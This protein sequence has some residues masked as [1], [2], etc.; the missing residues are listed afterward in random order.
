ATV[1]CPAD[2]IAW[3]FN[4][5]GSDI[6]H[7][8]VALARAIV[9]ASGKPELFIDGRKLSNEVRSIL[10]DVAALLEPDEISSRLT[11]F[12]LDKQTVLLDPQTTPQAID[13]A[14]REAGGT[15]THGRE[16]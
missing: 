1:L 2:S 14:I 9:P 4:I 13:T 8:P 11:A 15:I 6:A 5:R 12:G 3:T 16:P 7:N 10:S